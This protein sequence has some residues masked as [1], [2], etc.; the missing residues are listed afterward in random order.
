[1]LG[2]DVERNVKIHHVKRLFGASFLLGGDFC[3]LWHPGMSVR[4][5]E[6]L[7]QVGS[8]GWAPPLLCCCSQPGVPAGV[9]VISEVLVCSTHTCRMYQDPPLCVQDPRVH[10]HTEIKFIRG[11]QGMYY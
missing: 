3:L 1:M 4:A 9:W 11:G 8:A 6:V 10:E 7:G 5:W 2:M